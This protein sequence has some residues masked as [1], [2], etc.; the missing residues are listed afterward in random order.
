MNRIN[1]EQ[2]IEI[3]HSKYKS[4][5]YHQVKQILQQILQHSNEN[6]NVYLL[7]GNVHYCLSEYQQ[8]VEIYSYVTKIAPDMAAVHVNLGNSYAKLECFDNAI[9]SYEKAIAIDPSFLKVACRNSVYVHSMNQQIIPA[10]EMCGEVLDNSCDSNSLNATLGSKCNRSNPSPTYSSY[11]NIYNKLHIDGDLKNGI[12]PEE[13]YMGIST[14]P[15]IVAIKDLVDLTNS[16]TLLDYGSG[17]GIQYKTVLPE[18]ENHTEYQNLRDYW[19]VSEIHCYD[20]AY[21]PHQNLPNRQFDG[22]IST[23]VLEHCHQEDMKWIID[24]IFSSA[25]RFV[26]ANVA[27]Y[28][29]SKSLPNGKNAHCTIRPSVWWDVVLKSIAQNY[30]E[31]KYCVLVKY[32]WSDIKGDE[33]VFQVLSNLKPPELAEIE[34]SPS[35]ATIRQIRQE[36]EDL[37]PHTLH[38]KDERVYYPLVEVAVDRKSTV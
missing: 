31:V 14:I 2:A 32:I 26:F 7:M 20:P 34:L 10:L 8:A 21:P 33:S 28:K 30:P 16:N 29:A 17:K 3:A 27:C 38:G 9:I 6:I 11:V 18:D 13:M 12:Q 4:K 36:R 37:V 15:W 22:V 19:K 23:D 35:S 25:K 24:E 5:Q 1:L